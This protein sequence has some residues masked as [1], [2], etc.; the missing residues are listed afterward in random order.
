[1]TEHLNQPPDDTSD[2]CIND[3]CFN[4]NPDLC[5]NGEIVCRS[6][7]AVQ[8]TTWEPVYEEGRTA[9]LGGAGTAPIARAPPGIPGLPARQV[10]MNNQ[11]TTRTSTK[12]LVERA[13]GDSPFAGVT[14][15]QAL[16]ILSRIPKNFFHHS[17]VDTSFEAYGLGD[18]PTSDERRARAEHRAEHMAWGILK[19]LDEISPIGWRRTAVACGIQTTKAELFARDIKSSLGHYAE[20]GVWSGIDIYDALEINIP[21]QE[22]VLSTEI[23]RLLIW[24]GNSGLKQWELNEVRGSAWRLLDSWGATVYDLAVTPLSNKSPSLQAEVAVSMALLKLGHPDSLVRALQNEHPKNGSLAI[25]REILSGTYS[26]VPKSSTT[27]L[28]DD[29]SSLGGEE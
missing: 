25:R 26:P 3:D 1:M 19:L 12:E 2:Y 23:E 7:G 15:D 4:P 28:D 20:G 14:K 27:T 16:K 18:N 10:R 6:C 21:S 9:D 29:F 5:P 17:K 11:Q 24:L 13:I 22:L 8:G